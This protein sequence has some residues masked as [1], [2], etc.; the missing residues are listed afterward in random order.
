[1]KHI[2][3]IISAVITAAIVFTLSGCNALNN[4]LGSHIKSDLSE[5]YGKSF[6]VAA[7]GDRI[8][9]DTATAYV[10]ADDDPTMWFE[11]RTDKSGKVVFERYAFRLM[12]RDVENKINEAFD[13]CGIKSE[14]FVT[15]DARKDVKAEPDMTLDEFI[16]A[17][18]PENAI[19]SIIVSSG[20]NLTGENIAK[21]YNEVGEYLGSVDFAT[22][23]YV[24]TESDFD[25]VREQ[26]QHEVVSFDDQQLIFGGAK[27]DIKELL[28][29]VKDGELLWTADEIDAELS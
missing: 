17:N 16:A 29:K 14:C 24:L 18:S 23:L 2:K 11:V 9:R 25:T 20:D 3:I 27:D 7:L 6:T 22:G 12:C 5:K 4:S 26:V 13:N 28:I 1:M 19:T 8:D 21:V 10:F 15:F